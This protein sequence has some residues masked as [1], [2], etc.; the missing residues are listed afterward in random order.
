MASAFIQ[1]QNGK[2]FNIAEDFMQLMIYYIHEELKNPQ[3]TF[4]NKNL[5]VIGHEGIINGVASGYL[6][7]PW[8]RILVSIEEEQTMVQILKNVK[9]ALQNKGAFI[10]VSELQSIQT[11]DKDFKYLYSR[12]P[13]PV[14]EL[15]RI[16]DVLIQMLQGTWASNN[17][18]M[19]INYRY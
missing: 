7:L 1:Y 5:F 19:D 8:K 9:I 4:I 11:D 14:T 17:Y 10:S 15:I 18:D 2:G 6:T 16:I 13:F 3:Y 12:N